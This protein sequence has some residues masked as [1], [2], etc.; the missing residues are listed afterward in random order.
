MVTFMN[1]SS[2]TRRL[3]DELYQLSDELEDVNR[4]LIRLTLQRD[5]IIE[6]QRQIKVELEIASGNNFRDA[7]LKDRITLKLLQEECDL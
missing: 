3:R 7:I 4:Q 6:R 1:Q 2:N 5:E